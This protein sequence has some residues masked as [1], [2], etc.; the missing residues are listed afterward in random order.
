MDEVEQD[1][2]C[3]LFPIDFVQGM[4]KKNCLTLATLTG[5]SI[6]HCKMSILTVLLLF[7]TDWK[8]GSLCFN[9]STVM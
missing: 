7:T 9:V 3:R 4:E 5:T 6:D 2:I 8:M 1:E